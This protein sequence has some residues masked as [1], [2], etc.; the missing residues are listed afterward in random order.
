M[1]TTL[2]SGEELKSLAYG[3]MLKGTKSFL[4]GSDFK[5]TLGALFELSNRILTE[6]ADPEK[7][8]FQV[9]GF[10]P[11]GKDDPAAGLVMSVSFSR[12][13]SQMNTIMASF[14]FAIKTLPQKLDS[15]MG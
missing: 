6:Y 8:T 2:Q 9:P 14:E 4:T 1:Y 10:Q 5:K 13:E 3:G 11:L 7:E 15:M 12:I